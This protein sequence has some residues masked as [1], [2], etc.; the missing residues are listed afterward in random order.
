MAEET[1]VTPRTVT[2]VD[3]RILDLLLKKSLP[4]EQIAKITGLPQNVVNDSLVALHKDNR[5]GYKIE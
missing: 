1:N 3:M 4:A 2:A 5:I